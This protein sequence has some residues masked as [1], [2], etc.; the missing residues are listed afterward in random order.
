MISLR[1]IV[2]NI[3]N[4]LTLKLCACVCVFLYLR[5][6]EFE[7]RDYERRVERY[8]R[9]D[10]RSIDTAARF[11]EHKDRDLTRRDIGPVRD[12]RDRDDRR[13][14]ERSHPDDRFDR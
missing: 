5:F 11:E 2:N 10:A 14:D 6:N 12:L 3:F 4:F 9:Q 8:D 1:N 7:H 13:P